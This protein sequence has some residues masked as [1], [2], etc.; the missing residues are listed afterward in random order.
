MELCSVF[1]QKWKFWS[2]NTEA[3]IADPD[4]F[5]YDD[6]ENPIEMKLKGYE[7]ILSCD[8]ISAIC[9]NYI[10]THNTYSTNNLL[11]AFYFYLE[12]DA[13]IEG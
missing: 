4:S 3:I 11:Q 9:N 13:F 12:H 7:Y 5:E 6:D 8:D 2:L 10:A 1:T